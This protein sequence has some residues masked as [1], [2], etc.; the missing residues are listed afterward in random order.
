M[1]SWKISS[2][3]AISF[4]THGQFHQADVLHLQAGAFDDVIESGNFDGIVH[5]ASPVTLKIEK[6]EKVVGPAVAGTKSILD[7]TLN[8]G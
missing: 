8:H 4:V 1:Q 6:D 2:R 3:S 5:M 7:A